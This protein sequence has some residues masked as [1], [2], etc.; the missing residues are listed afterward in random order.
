M[1]KSILIVPIIAIKSADS[2]YR[3]MDHGHSE[4]SHHDGQEAGHHGH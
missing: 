1:D 2:I 3:M 4:H